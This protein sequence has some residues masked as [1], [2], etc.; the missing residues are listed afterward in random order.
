MSATRRHAERTTIDLAVQGV[1][2]SLAGLPVLQRVAATADAATRLRCHHRA[3]EQ[4]LI[5]GRVDEGLEA[6]RG[7]LSEAHG[8]LP[9]SWPAAMAQLLWSRAGRRLRGVRWKPRDASE[10][11]GGWFSSG[12]SPISEMPPRF[13][14]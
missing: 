3:A 11:V 4:L 12:T 5:N 6:L 14:W 10:M 1:S 9:T 8:S 13:S 2:T 7:V